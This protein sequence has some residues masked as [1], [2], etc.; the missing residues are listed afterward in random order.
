MWPETR[1]ETSLFKI[2]FSC[3]DN[4]FDPSD[5]PCGGPSQSY[6]NVSLNQSALSLYCINQLEEGLGGDGWNETTSQDF[7][8]PLLSEEGLDI[9]RD[10]KLA[11][12]KDGTLTDLMMAL[13]TILC[14]IL[15]SIVTYLCYTR[16]ISSLSRYVM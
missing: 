3:A 11:L 16:G 15:T 4:L 5:Q 2:L 13:I 12:G 8:K 6:D 9:L 7:V 14:I 10:I 1:C